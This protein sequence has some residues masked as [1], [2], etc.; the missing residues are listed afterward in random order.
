[1]KARNGP[2]V[3]VRLGRFKDR[4]IRPC[5]RC[6]QPYKCGCGAEYRSHEEKETDVALGATMVADAA[7][8]LADSSLLISADTDLRPALTAIRLV[9]PHQRLYLGMPAGNAAPS[10]Y[11]QSVGGLGQFFI[12]ESVLNQAQLPDA[13]HDQET[14]RIYQ[15]PAKWR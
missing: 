10:R 15:R 14:G 1:M 8:G 3:D 9:V 5:G 11:W 7:M 4:T 12:R 13:V 6:G 2:R